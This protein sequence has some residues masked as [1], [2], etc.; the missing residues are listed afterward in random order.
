MKTFPQIPHS[1]FFWIIIFY[2]ISQLMSLSTLT[3]VMLSGL[4][5]ILA[6]QNSQ[7]EYL[8][9][10]PSYS[11]H[12]EKGKAII[13]MMNLQILPVSSKVLKATV[14]LLLCCQQ[15]VILFITLCWKLCVQYTLRS[16]IDLPSWEFWDNILKVWP[17][18]QYFVRI[19]VLF[20]SMTHGWGEPE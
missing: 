14:C 7:I 12:A 16:R 5:E 2:K 18:P 9:R 4:W 8:W 3:S 17:L 10:V 15:K 13:D 20:G 11:L 19:I 6:A 1:L